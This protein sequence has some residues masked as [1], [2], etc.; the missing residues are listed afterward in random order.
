MILNYKK[1]FTPLNLAKPVRSN[2]TGFT[3][4][5]LL[6]VLALI[7]I[8]MTLVFVSL[9]PIARFQDTRNAKRWADINAIIS[10]IR[11][12][13]ID[14]DGVFDL[15]IQQMQAELYYQIGT[16]ENCNETCLNPTVTLNVGCVDLDSMTEKGYLPIFPYDPNAEGASDEHTKY[17]IM[18]DTRNSLTVGACS[19][20]LGTNDTVVPISI[21]L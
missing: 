21:T 7:A 17:Y 5:E 11:T 12:D 16:G 19:E 18:K 8:L 15:G 2:L 14:H 9:N 1:G 4:I 13:Q 20:E 10:A 3:L 6:I